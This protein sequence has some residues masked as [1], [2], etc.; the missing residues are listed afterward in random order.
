MKK[1]I[2]LIALIALGQPISSQN[3]ARLGYR[4]IPSQEMKTFVQNEAIYWSQVAA[5]LKEKGQITGWSIHVKRSGGRASEANVMTRV[6][7]GSMENLNNLGKNYAA[8]EKAVQNAMDPQTWALI[9]DNLKQEKYNV[10]N[11]IVQNVDEVWAK[12]DSWNYVV[13]NFV[14]AT[15]PALYLSEES[16][17][18][19]PFFSKLMKQGKTKQKGWITVN[20]LSPQ[21][22]DYAFNSYTVDFYEKFSDAFTPFDM[23]SIDWPEEMESLGKLKTPGFWKRVIWQRVMYLDENNELI[24]SW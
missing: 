5:H 2:L 20:V 19:K 22:Y 11:L 6:A 8:A 14:K 3:V 13:Q 9:E 10:A 24:T 18:M 16:R 4:N 23:Q 17:I 21:G 15:N 1:L 12:D 7:P